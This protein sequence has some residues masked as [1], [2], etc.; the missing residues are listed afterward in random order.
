MK[1]E[2]LPDLL[3]VEE[4]AAF[5][6]RPLSSVYRLIHAGEIPSMR[7]GRRYHVPKAAL[8]RMLEEA[9]EGTRAPS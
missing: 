6:R 7:L 8:V 3:T 1:L 5:L 2:D 4:T 9:A